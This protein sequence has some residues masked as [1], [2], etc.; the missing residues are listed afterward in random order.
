[1]GVEYFGM[2]VLFAG[3][4][5]RVTDKVCRDVVAGE[6]SGEPCLIAG[7]VTEPGAGPMRRRR[8]SSTRRR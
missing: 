7:L 3:W 1:M 8:S 2:S 6:K 5:T 4:N